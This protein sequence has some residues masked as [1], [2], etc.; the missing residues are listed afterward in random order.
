MQYKMGIPGPL[1]GSTASSLISSTEAN[2]IASADSL[3]SRFGPWDYVVFVGALLV[4]ALIGLYYACSGGK[5]RTTSEMLLGNRSLPVFPVS[6][7][8]LA[9]FL[10]AI[11]I[12][13]TATEMYR[14]GTQYML[15][16]LSYFIV[17]PS[18]AYLYMPVFYRLELTSAH[19]YLERRFSKTCRMLATLIFSIQMIV[20][21]AIVLY[22]P[23][24]ALSQVTGISVW[25]SVLSIGTVCTFYTSI[26]GIKAV[27]WTDAFQIGI[28]YASIMA[29]V[30]KGSTDLGGMDNVIKTAAIHD[31]ITFFNF[32]PDPTDRH[33]VWGLI[34]GCN[35][36]WLSIYGTSQAMVQ[37]YLTLSSEEKARRAIWLNLPGLVF[38]LFVC[39]LAGLVMFAKYHSC[40]PLQ[41][42]RIVATDQLLP[43]FVMDT[44]G[45]FPGLP[46]FFVSGIFSG[47]LSTVSSSVNSLATVALEDV[48]KG[49]LERELSDQMATWVT[50]AFAIFFGVLAIAL[51]YVAQQLGNVLQAALAT[52]GILGGPILG[53]F[54]LGIFIPQANK[55]GAVVGL[56][57]SL[58]LTFWIGIGNFIYKPP[59]SPAPISV[60][61]CP[62]WIN[63]TL[64]TQL[65]S[66]A[67][68]K[69]IVWFY[70]I[71][72]VWYSMIAT[73]LVIVVGLPVSVCTGCT[74]PKQVDDR[75]ISPLYNQFIKTF[76][77]F[78]RYKEKLLTSQGKEGGDDMKM[79]PVNKSLNVSM[80]GTLNAVFDHRLENMDF[81]LR[82]NN[83]E[84]SRL[85][86]ANTNNYAD[87]G[88]ISSHM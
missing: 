79:V 27:I 9:S 59:V 57:I 60:A 70:R 73:L 4:S 81:T 80:S 13:G 53:V 12:L 51:V 21:M 75:L 52:F 77:P 23:S 68:A 61:G 5:Q 11:T 25:T 74:I 43:L 18:A 36:T 49:Y 66:S 22:A 29:V 63:A 65:S 15:I 78:E 16:I 6:L 2:D 26:G 56:L 85:K 33:T 83:S 46:G 17:I 64:P 86:Y 67:T 32:N 84:S 72:Y 37:R 47:A 41:A 54:T 3:V 10:S 50:K 34:I 88:H 14:F 44:L 40:D 71:S 69:E 19:E 30:I 76:V 31:R 35:F 7:S 48:V 62:T 39:S 87:C 82:R 8:I 45:F 24:L 38:L 58:A 55:H 1:E 42:K 20:Y 28:M